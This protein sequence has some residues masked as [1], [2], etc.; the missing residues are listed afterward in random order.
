MVLYLVHLVLYLV[1]LRTRKV[2]QRLCIGFSAPC[3]A[4]VWCTSVC[5]STVHQKCAEVGC[6]SDCPC[7]VH[8]R[9]RMVHHMVHTCG[10][11]V[12]HHTCGEPCVQVWCTRLCIGFGAPCGVHV[13]SGYHTC[14]VVG[15]PRGASGNNL[16]FC[17]RTDGA[18]PLYFSGSG[19]CIPVMR[20][21]LCV[22]MH[23]IF[24]IVQLWLCFATS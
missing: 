5:G 4:H 11:C 21:V 17:S 22:C 1:H 18:K 12:V 6:T 16:L 23:L 8:R 24:L 3:G 13:L 19:L 15:G 20:F 10:A 14:V 2:H 7:V 9:V